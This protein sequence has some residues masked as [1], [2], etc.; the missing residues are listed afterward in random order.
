LRSWNVVAGQKAVRAAAF[1]GELPK[2]C[3][4]ELQF[5]A[6]VMTQARKLKIPPWTSTGNKQAH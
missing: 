2:Q 4:R 1:P 6:I 5:F 3:S